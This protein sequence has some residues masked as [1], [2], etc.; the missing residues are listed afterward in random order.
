VEGTRVEARDRPEPE[1]VDALSREPRQEWGVRQGDEHVRV[2][3]EV[4]VGGAHRSDIGAGPERVHE[5]REGVCPDE[6]ASDRED[7]AMGQRFEEL[8]FGGRRPGASRR[9]R[10]LDQERTPV[11]VHPLGRPACGQLSGPSPHVRGV[12]A[13]VRLTHAA[14]R[15]LLDVEVHA[16]PDR[17]LHHGRGASLVAPREGRGQELGVGGLRLERQAGDGEHVGIIRRGGFRD[18]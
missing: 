16:T 6:D 12:R 8:E 18:V 4:D 17:L 13:E 2:V 1:A 5:R 3:D 7:P 9:A 15:A 11:L 14:E 10:E